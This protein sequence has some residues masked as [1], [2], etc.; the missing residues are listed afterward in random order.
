M[1]YTT[2]EGIAKAIEAL[3]AGQ[4]VAYPTETVYGL[5]VDPFQDSAMD[6]LFKV[7]QRDA[8]KPV[9]LIVAN[10]GQLNGVVSE[11][12]EKAARYMEEFWPGPLS[13][14]LP[15]ADELPDKVTAGSEKVCVRCP[16]SK[17]A[18][19]LCEA[20]GGAITSTSANLSGSAAARS[21]SQIML[22]GVLFGLDGGTLELNPPSTVFDPDTGQVFREGVV[23]EEDLLLSQ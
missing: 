3:H 18:K 9:L 2:P 5:G 17:T 1:L 10:K 4:V 16:A 13:L 8:N 15:K 19:L 7:K 22:P 23:L 21:L 6:K 12:S 20:F 11:I 14:L